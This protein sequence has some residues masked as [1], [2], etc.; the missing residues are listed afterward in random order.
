MNKKDY[1]E[2]LGLKKD[3]SADD[4]K[5]TYRNLAKELHPDKNP[6][7]KEA[8]E[9]FKE[10]SEAYEV[11]SNTE[12]KA[13][14]DRFGHAKQKQRRESYAYHSSVIR[15]GDNITLQ[16]K[17]TLEE[18]YFGV[19][20][21]YKYKRNDKCDDCKG[22]GGKNS[23]D[24]DVCGGSGVVLNVIQTPFGSIRQPMTCHICDGIG[25]KHSELCST[26]K[27][28][29]LKSVEETI[30]VEVP[31]GVLNGMT[32]VMEGK[33]HAI[34]NG[35]HG[36]LHI[37]VVELPHDVYVRNGNDLKMTLKLTYPELVLG[38]KVDIDTID[39]SKIRITVP[40]YSDIGT[41]LR[42]QKKG[43]KQLNNDNRGD[44]VITLGISI[45]KEI[46]EDT[47]KLLNK[48]KEEK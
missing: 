16:V 24:C 6:N 8:E 5:K 47:R 22:L 39:G 28:S 40:E 44:I 30:N 3:A 31:S 29:G 18:I 43:L 10:V 17:L 36:N 48:L 38:E 14:Y 41:N 46:D 13:N 45:P 4:I 32:Y 21:R 15:V 19:K 27:A 42:V 7:N 37:Q 34:K 2:S 26:C 33:G 1:Y 20:R 25:L 12:K 9:R 35:H 23:T 11:L